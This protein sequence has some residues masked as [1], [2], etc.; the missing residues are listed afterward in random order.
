MEK[1]V[2]VFGDIDA[3]FDLGWARFM[4]AFSLIKMGNS[5]RAV[6]PLANAL[7][8]FADSS[9]LS[10]MALILDV[11]GMVMMADSRETAA[12]LLGAAR[13]IKSETGIAIGDVD[14][15]QYPEIDVFLAEMDDSEQAAYEEGFNATLEEAVEA[16][17][18]AL[19]SAR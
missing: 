6:E 15:N 2:E 7:A 14:V 10:A 5:E 4:L 3:P 17:R 12:Y 11:A 1:A 16:A 13:H 19:N 8:I 9:D 18:S